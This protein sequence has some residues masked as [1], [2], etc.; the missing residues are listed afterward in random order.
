[1]EILAVAAVL[2]LA[3]GFAIAR[4]TIRHRRWTQCPVCRMWRSNIGDWCSSDPPTEDLIG[5]EGVCYQCRRKV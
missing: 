5:P 2:C 3:A 1:M 4:L